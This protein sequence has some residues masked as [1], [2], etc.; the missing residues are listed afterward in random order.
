METALTD[1]SLWT[2]T[3][4]PSASPISMR[5]TMPDGPLLFLSETA[6]VFSPAVSVERSGFS[7]TRVFFVSY[8]RRLPFSHIAPPSSNLNLNEA[9]FGAEGSENLSRKNDSASLAT[10]ASEFHSQPLCDTRSGCT[11]LP[12][13]RK[14][15]S[16]F[17]LSVRLTAAEATRKTPQKTSVAATMPDTPTRLVKLIP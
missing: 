3:V 13:T 16:H 4:E 8:G 1:S 2:K 9:D 5:N 10:A 11:S 17:S 14:S 7:G 6:S 15:L 12:G